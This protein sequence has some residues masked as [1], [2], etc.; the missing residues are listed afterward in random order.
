M[1]KA[2]TSS[3]SS[4]DPIPT[5]SSGS[6]SPLN[7]TLHV[8]VLRARNLPTMDFGKRQDPFVLVQLDGSNPKSWATTDPVFQGG[9][10]PEWSEKSNNELEL[11]Y[12]A[13]LHEKDA[14]LTVEVFSDETGDDLIGTGQI[15]VSKVAKSQTKLASE[16][17]VRLKD[18]IGGTANR[19]EVVLH[20]WFGPPVRKAF[21]A[22]QRASKL[23]DARDSVVATAW[24]LV[25]GVLGSKY[26]Q[27]PT[28]FF[29][30][31]RSVGVALAAL[32]GIALAGAVAVFLAVAVPTAVV[33]AFTFPLWI[34]PFLVT[35]FFT[36]PLWIP[37]VLLV[38]LFGAFIGT[39]VFGLGVTSRPVR[40]QGAL[41]TSRIKHSEMG[42]RVVYEKEV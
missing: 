39:F 14:V 35:A 29:K 28:E 26:L 41:L 23:L 31:H 27:G 22:A 38:G 30:K 17:T 21:R 4:T 8:K 5:T 7:G 12:D 18:G 1:A 15:N 3:S 9:T 16:Y 2:A 20:V 6:G 36:A 37:V 34:I 33:A 42:K 11:F 24:T 40:R 32:V 13:S 10:N 25:S 19:G